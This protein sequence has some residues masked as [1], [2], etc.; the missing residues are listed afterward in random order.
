MSPEGWEGQLVTYPNINLPLPAGCPGPPSPLAPQVWLTARQPAARQPAA[1]LGE[2]S[3]LTVTCLPVPLLARRWHN[4][5]E[6]TLGLRGQ[7]DLAWSSVVL[8]KNWASWVLWASVYMMTNH[9]PILRIKWDILWTSSAWSQHSI[10][11]GCSFAAL[12]IGFMWEWMREMQ[13]TWHVIA[14]CKHELL[15]SSVSS[16]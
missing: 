5:K 11:V 9:N 8:F 6:E 13:G 4:L 2:L 12:F 1:P 15:V 3:E 16:N 14:L 7:A 10:N